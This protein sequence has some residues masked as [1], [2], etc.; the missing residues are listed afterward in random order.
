ML[1]V[2]AGCLSRPVRPSLAGLFY[3]PRK[4]LDEI[5]ASRSGHDGARSGRFDRDLT[6]RTMPGITIRHVNAGWLEAPPNPRVCCHCLLISDGRSAALVDTGIGLAD[7]ADPLR[8]VGQQAIEMA[9][10]Q[11]DAASTLRRQFERDDFPI[12]SIEHVVMTHLDADH[13]GGLADFP[14]AAVHVS[15]EELAAVERGDT[16]YRD[17]QFDHGP[18]WR[19]YSA[20]HATEEAWFGLAARR[21]NV[22][23]NAVVLLVPL[24]GHTAGHC[25]VAIEGTDG[26]TLH[27]GDAYYLRGELTDPAHP[28]DRIAAQRAV[29][30]A[31]RRR[32]LAE[33]RRL[34]HDHKD[35]VRLFGYHDVEELPLTAGG[36]GAG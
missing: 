5:V 22:G 29:N 20:T 18:R 21:V 32:S 12:E 27:T 26:W 6:S 7:V 2:N 23:M 15:A 36:R 11:F 24:F 30:D 4:T 31:A 35:E 9:G 25:G 3:A 34:A 19:A 1:A 10:F 8:R 14:W 16:R 28:V 33:L 13:A 17:A